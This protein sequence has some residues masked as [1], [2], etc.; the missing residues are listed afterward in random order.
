MFKK[1]QRSFVSANMAM[2]TVILLLAFTTICCITSQNINNQNRLK[3]D[4]IH[5]TTLRYHGYYLNG[6]G[7]NLQVSTAAEDYTD[8]FGIII[9]QYDRYVFDSTLGMLSQELAA[10]AIQETSGK[11]SGE[12]ILNERIFQFTK[13]PVY[14]KI[15]SVNRETLGEQFSQIAYLDITSTKRGLLELLVAFA[16]VCFATLLAMLG[17]SVLFARRAMTPIEKAYF[18][19]KQFVQDASHELKTPLSSIRANLDVLS[20]NQAETIQ[21]QEKWIRHIYYETE[22]MRNLVVELLEL[23]RADNL[24]KKKEGE[25][26]CVS[27]LLEKSLLSVEAV[28]YEKNIILHQQIEENISVRC[29]ELAWNK[30]LEFCWTMPASIPIQVK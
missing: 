11:E 3:L 2:I 27:R 4:N 14:M 17:I 10:Q 9:D 8:A 24:G 28:L 15:D 12:I 7:N 22:R 21:S 1:L 19:Q 23:A 13:I 25:E 20:E 16:V 30:S 29:N 5:S 18:K 26:I 6:K